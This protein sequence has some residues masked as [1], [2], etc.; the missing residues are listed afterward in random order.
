MTT[1]FILSFLYFLLLPVSY[2]LILR[3]QRI[4]RTRVAPYKLYNAMSS[5]LWLDEKTI[6]DVLQSD[7]DIVRVRNNYYKLYNL[8][9]INHLA[10]ELNSDNFNKAVACFK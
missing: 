8:D 10:D 2:L 7:I 6:M 3:W 4:K 9:L 1:F 5:F